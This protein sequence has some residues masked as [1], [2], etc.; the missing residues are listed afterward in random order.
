[1][2]FFQH[3]ILAMNAGKHKLPAFK[4]FKIGCTEPAYLMN[5]CDI[6]P[7]ISKRL[8]VTVHF[9]NDVNVITSSCLQFF[10]D[11]KNLKVPS[12]AGPMPPPSLAGGIGSSR[13][14]RTTRHKNITD[15]GF[16][17]ID[18]VFTRC[19]DGVFTRCS[20]HHRYSLVLSVPHAG[21]PSPAH[22]ILCQCCPAVP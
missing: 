9:F 11:G 16:L 2:L 15:A 12:M 18:G 4:H 1:M 7:M 21:V 6:F 10:N 17:L 14:A 13:A 3:R 5:E 19:S 22:T 20:D 8:L